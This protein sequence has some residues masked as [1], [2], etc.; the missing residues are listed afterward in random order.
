MI[1]DDDRCLPWLAAMSDWEFNSITLDIGRPETEDEEERRSQRARRAWAVLMGMPAP[2]NAALLWKLDQLLGSVSNSGC[3]NWGAEFL[4]QTVAD[5][6][7]LLSP[8]YSK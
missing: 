6:R 7:R 1:A 2:D 5:Y 3:E 8:A 4:A